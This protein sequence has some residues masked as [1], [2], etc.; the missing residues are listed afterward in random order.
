MALSSADGPA[1]TQ[2]SPL[3]RLGLRAVMG[4][5]VG[6]SAGMP[7]CSVPAPGSAL[8]PKL[9]P[10]VSQ[11][12]LLR[13]RDVSNIDHYVGYLTCENVPSPHRHRQ[14]SVTESAACSRL[15]TE[16]THHGSISPGTINVS[17]ASRTA[18]LSEMRSSSDVAFKSRERAGRLRP[19]NLRMPEMRSRSLADYL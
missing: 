10:R 19:S 16:R 4:Q 1:T 18:P 5:P 17:F 9:D 6:A 13:F 14:S 11:L 15:N 7:C 8:C 2:G 12:A 3:V